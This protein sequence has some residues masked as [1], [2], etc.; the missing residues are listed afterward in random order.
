MEKEDLH[1]Q[2]LRWCLLGNNFDFEVHDK[3]KFGDVGDPIDKSTV[4]HLSD[5]E[6]F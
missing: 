1:P 6:P 2:L 5:P 3:A 4:H